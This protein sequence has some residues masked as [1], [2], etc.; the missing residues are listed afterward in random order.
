MSDIRRFAA[1]QIE[2]FC[3]GLTKPSPEQAC[4]LLDASQP[5][6]AAM[7]R[8]GSG[9]HTRCGIQSFRGAEGRADVVGPVERWSQGARES[10][11]ERAA[12]ARVPVCPL[13]SDSTR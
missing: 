5:L 4:P 3:N 10:P 12:F 2:A 1:G 9:T 13:T 7:E 6:E 8:G 11:G